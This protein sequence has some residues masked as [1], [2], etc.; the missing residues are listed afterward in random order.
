MHTA[1]ERAGGTPI[2]RRTPWEADQRRRYFE[3]ANVINPPPPPTNRVALWD[4][5]GARRLSGA[6]APLPQNLAKVLAENPHYEVYDG[7]DCWESFAAWS[8]DA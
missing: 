8:V 6:C 7:Q 1:I 5:K 4:T 2:L 3:H